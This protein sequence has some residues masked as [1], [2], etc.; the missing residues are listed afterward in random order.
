MTKS[1]E[2]KGKIMLTQSRLRLL[3]TVAGHQVTGV[4]GMSA[5]ERLEELR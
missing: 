1:D 4:I 2:G 3:L 5:E